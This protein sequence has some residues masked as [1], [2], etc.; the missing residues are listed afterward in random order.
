MRFIIKTSEENKN[1]YEL[2]FNGNFV[3]Y[4]KST[5]FNTLANDVSKWLEEQ[6]ISFTLN[7]GE[8]YDLP[9][10]SE[11]EAE[12]SSLLVNGK[13]KKAIDL[14]KALAY[15]PLKRPVI[16]SSREVISFGKYW[17]TNSYDK[18]FT[19]FEQLSQDLMEV[20]YVDEPND[21]LSLRGE[22]VYHPNHGTTHGLRQYSLSKQYLELIK[23]NGNSVFREVANSLTAEEQACLRLA[24]FLFR[25]GRT[26]EL[27]WTSDASYGPRSAAIF[28]QIALELEFSPELVDILTLSFDYHKDYSETDLSVQDKNKLELF[29]KI[30]KMSHESDLVRCFEKYEE[31]KA[32]IVEELKQLLDPEQDC[33]ELADSYLNYAADLCR[34]TGSKIA[35]LSLLQTG[36]N[37]YRDLKGNN[38]LAIDWANPPTTKEKMYSLL[39]IRPSVFPELMSPTALWLNTASHSPEALGIMGWTAEQAEAMPTVACMQKEVACL[40]THV[41][42]YHA[43]TKSSYALDLFCRELRGLLEKP[44]K[45]AWIRNFNG[46]PP[47][48]AYKDLSEVLARQ[49]EV[50]V[51]DNQDNI[52]WHLLSSNPSLWQNS[53]VA[54]EESTIDFFHDNHSVISLE[55]T[56]LINDLLDKEGV[57]LDQPEEREEI[58]QQ[59]TALCNDELFGT[60]GVIYQYLIPFH[61]VESTAYIAKQNGVFDEENPG[62]LDTLLR[63]K[64]PEQQLP[65]HN[66][67]QVRLFVPNLLDERYTADQ[68]VVENHLGMSEQMRARFE[69][70]IRNLA[71]EA[72][73][74][75]HKIAKPEASVK[76]LWTKN[77]NTFYGSGA[78]LKLSEE[79]DRA[80][81]QNT[82][83]NLSAAKNTSSE[84][85]EQAIV[86]SEP[87]AR[88]NLKFSEES[89]FLFNDASEDI[90]SFFDNDNDDD[91]KSVALSN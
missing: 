41:S 56:K 64:Y 33:S 35:T 20:P 79:A 76:V 53:D 44:N 8:K 2:Q 88:I 40:T 91:I 7:A 71:Q 31:V 27:G 55:F 34:L 83:V 25:V 47:G 59:F 72:I 58:F 38:R 26:N 9:I 52:S 11:Q 30:L 77:R 70:G 16:F 86:Q 80:R 17:E 69:E 90:M 82:N 3:R 42:A 14:P 81:L 49:R 5:E 39:P 37:Y 89:S 75:T 43:T 46:T 54:S 21:Q 60:Q 68:I 4:I 62:A 32:P 18:L 84:T 6:G 73:T 66:T 10:S 87:Q 65:N 78:P 74:L 51:N 45:T 13:N 24:A 12:L 1:L 19:L 15:S 67:L 61:L 48:K 57:L 36:D 23:Q 29:T 63:L 85:V 28:K 50:Q 22:V